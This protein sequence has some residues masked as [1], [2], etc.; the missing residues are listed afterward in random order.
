MKRDSITKKVMLMMLTLLLPMVVL[1]DDFQ[2]GDLWYR[3][4]GNNAKVIKYQYTGEYTGAITIPSTV[5]SN[6]GVTL[7]VTSIG[8]S[9]F[10]ECK[11]V[12]SVSIPNTVTSIGEKAFLGCI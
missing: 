8:G 2:H 1:A 10:S 5:R 7:K 12:T 3:E 4:D 6:R 9:A 11:G